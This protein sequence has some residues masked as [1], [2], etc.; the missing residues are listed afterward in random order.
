M[1]DKSTIQGSFCAAVSAKYWSDQLSLGGGS[2]WVLYFSMDAGINYMNTLLWNVAAM[3]GALAGYGASISG[4]VEPTVNAVNNTMISALI[5]AIVVA[6]GKVI[7][8]FVPRIT[9]P[10]QLN[11]SRI[12][13]LGGGTGINNN[14]TDFC[15]KGHG[16]TMDGTIVTPPQTPGSCICP[17]ILVDC[18]RTLYP[19]FNP[20]CQAR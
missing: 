18:I 10:L 19:L 14:V 4:L 2:A 7:L 8:N 5:G 17:T 11:L 12:S 15:Q 3:N 1:T 13:G 6:G 20:L 9:K 16:P